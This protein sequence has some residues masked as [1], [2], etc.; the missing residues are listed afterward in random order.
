MEEFL[1]LDSSQSYD[2]NDA[3]AELSYSW[4]CPVL[5]TTAGYTCANFVS[6][7]NN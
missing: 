1:I 5:V 2:P 6:G 7:T 3:S 4:T